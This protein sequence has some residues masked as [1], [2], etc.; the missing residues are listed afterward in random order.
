MSFL[1]DQLAWSQNEQTQF[2]N[3]TCQLHP[4][5]KIG[6]KVYVVARHFAFERDKKLP[7]LKNAGLW[8]IVQ[9]ID[10]K[11]YELAISETLKAAG[12]TSIF[13]VWKLYLAPN[14]LFPGQILPS[15]LPIKIN[16]E[17][18]KNFEVHEKW[19]VLKV[20][21]CHQIKQYGVQYKTT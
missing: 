8:K 5:Y 17:D 9:N 7:N 18:N 2:A 11:A 15:G 3:G 10:N 1:Q 4:K 20:I 19:E 14:S 21:D 6:D 13:H 16:A 12:L